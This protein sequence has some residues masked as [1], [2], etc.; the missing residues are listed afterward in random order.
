MIFRVL[1]T[2]YHFF[3]PVRSY[4]IEEWSKK[5][6]DDLRA[7]GAKI[8]EN[9]DIIDASIDMGTPFLLSIGNNVT[10][11]NCRLLTHDAS[12]KK[13]LGY[14]KVG[15]ITIGNNVFIGADAI[16][17]PNTTIGDNVIIGSGSV[18]ARDI[19]NNSVVVGN[20]CRIICKCDEYIAKQQARMEN[21]PVYNFVGRELNTS[22][23][24]EE[25]NH[26]LAVG[27]GFFR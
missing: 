3:R 15:K 13:F 1:K 26:L 25:R 6:I 5:Q 21:L 10:I 2:I 8:G 24:T 7:G 12:T 14:T 27:T 22:E 23:R 9:V 11:T 18:I 19:P 16:I 17:L 4:T 20:P